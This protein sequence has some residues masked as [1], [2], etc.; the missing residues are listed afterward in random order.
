MQLCDLLK[1]I[2][3]VVL[4]VVPLKTKRIID[5]KKTP[6]NSVLKTKYITP[7]DTLEKKVLYNSLVIVV[8]FIS[9]I[10][11]DLRYCEQAHK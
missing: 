4:K 7:K 6:Q 5:K 8:S 2:Y 11:I 3:S 9:F 1:I 10:C